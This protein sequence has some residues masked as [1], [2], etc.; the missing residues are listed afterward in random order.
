MSKPERDLKMLRCA[1]QIEEKTM[2][3]RCKQLLEAGKGEEANPPLESPEGTQPSRCLDFS[4]V[5]P[6]S[7]F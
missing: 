7:H 4:P 6:L 2:S 1:S 3:Q 5:R